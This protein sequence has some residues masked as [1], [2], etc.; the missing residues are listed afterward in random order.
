MVM[1]KASSGDFHLQQGV[2]KSFWTRSM[3]VAACSMF[4]GN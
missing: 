2:G 4:C 3:M 1:K